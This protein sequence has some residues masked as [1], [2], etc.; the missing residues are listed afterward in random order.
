M[1]DSGIE[2]T[3]R[4]VY[5]LQHGEAQPKSRD[6]QRPLTP[7][8]REAVERVA[9]WAA[10]AGLKVEQIRHSGKL[11]SEQ[12]AAIFAQQLQPRQGTTSFPGLGANDDVRP[13]ADELASCPD[14]VMIV[15]H[16]PFLGRLA[17]LMLAGEPERHLV[18]FRNGGLVGLVREEEKWTIACLVPPELVTRQ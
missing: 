7:A 10:G 5:L 6:P 1:A 4:W 8:G 11:R 9:A 12:T 14:S 3:T 18:R 16:L 2:R 15:G 13:I 17:G